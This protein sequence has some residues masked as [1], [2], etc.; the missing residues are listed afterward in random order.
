M[1]T[2][3]RKI[4][5]SSGAIIPAALLKK[6]NLTEGDAI[7]IEENGSN[8]V[9]SPVTKRPKYKLDELLAQCDSNAPVSEELSDWDNSPAVGN[10]IW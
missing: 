10:E 9:I 8:I 6:Y 7:N 1:R 3:I 2:T 5:N 4:G